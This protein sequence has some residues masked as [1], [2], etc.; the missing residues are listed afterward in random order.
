MLNK[1]IV[2]QKKK[3]Y[4]GKFGGQYVPNQIKKA[5]NNVAKYYNHFKDDPKF[6]QELNYY[7]KDY[8]GRPTSLYFAE[9]LTKYLGGAKIY[10]KREDLNHLGA[11][12]LNNV[13][14]QVLLA[15]RMGKTRIIAET[16]AGQHGTATAAGAAKFGMKCEIYMGAE[17]TKRQSL[18]VFRMKLLGAKV[19]A[20]KTGTAT[21]KDAIDAAFAD[22][23]TNLDDTYYVV[24]SAVG[25]YPYPEMVKDFQSVISKEMK[26]QII[27]K[28]GH[29]PD[30]V[31]ACVGGGSNAIGSFSHF[32][33]NKS[34]RLIGA[35]AAGQGANT[36]KN[37][38]TLTKGTIGIGHG[39][40]SYFLQD[41]K[42]NMKPTYSISAGLDYP[43]VGPEHSLLK[44]IKRAEYYPITD[45]EAVNAF[46]LLSK[47]EGIIP[48]LESS[49]AVAQAVK[50]APKMTSDKVIVVNLSGR[51]DKD[52]NQVAKFTNA[53]I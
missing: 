39:M 50:M 47:T 4:F 44:D 2:N 24:G 20:V 51:G 5:L 14:G 31:I 23:A 49:H 48:A 10:L 34:V 37:A 26:K 41:A 33:N 52:V 36:S 38:A 25:P 35:E 42:G 29:L 8:S 6:R 30:A 40:K 45:K 43:G 7:L 28:E 53:K 21:L 11:H 1:S 3:G 46:V 17:D 15:K 12:K 16:G 27:E 18:N 13:L 19:H 32:I 9:S 22:F